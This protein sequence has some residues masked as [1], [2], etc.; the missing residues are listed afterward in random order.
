VRFLV[1]RDAEKNID[2]TIINEQKYYLKII[3]LFR[4]VYYENKNLNILLVRNIYRIDHDNECFKD[5]LGDN[6]NNPEQFIG[7]KLQIFRTGQIIDYKGYKFPAIN[8]K[9][10]VYNFSLKENISNKDQCLKWIEDGLVTWQRGNDCQADIN[11][12]YTDVGFTGEMCGSIIYDKYCAYIEI[13]NEF[14]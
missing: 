12:E 6:W 9:C 5:Y 14:L 13:P 1:E 4:Y 8:Y 2:Y 11:P 10:G 7:N 3:E